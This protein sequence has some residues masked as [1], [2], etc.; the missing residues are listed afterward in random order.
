MQL[1]TF[2]LEVLALTWELSLSALYPQLTTAALRHNFPKTWI[3]NLFFVRV[4]FIMR[5]LTSL[6]IHCIGHITTGSWK[7]RGNQYIQFAGT[8]YNMALAF[9][10]LINKY[11]PFNHSPLRPNKLLQ[12]QRW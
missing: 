12:F 10:I 8:C 1:M 3:K 9:G 2:P 4:L 6:S 11:K 7:G 5:V